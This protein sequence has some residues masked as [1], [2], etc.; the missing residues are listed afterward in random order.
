MQ[1]SL[2]AQ[3]GPPLLTSDL[4]S[5]GCHF[6]AAFLQGTRV[7]LALL[8]LC[9]VLWSGPR[10]QHPIPLPGAP[11]EPPL[12]LTLCKADTQKASWSRLRCSHEPSHQQLA[13]LPVLCWVRPPA[14]QNSRAH[15]QQVE[16]AV[17][18]AVVSPPSPQFRITLQAGNREARG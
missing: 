18:T 8:Q 2:G 4:E 7:G 15:P 16:G 13:S 6:H 9:A 12:R 10:S 5:L 17:G 14:L 1:K 3:L 11:H